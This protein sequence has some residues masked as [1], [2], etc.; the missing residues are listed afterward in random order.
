MAAKS[1]TSIP[2]TGK[3]KSGK[4]FKGTY[5]V[6]RFISKNG[7]TYALGTLSGKLGNRSVHR[8]N[9]AMPASVRGLT[10]GYMKDAVASC[11]VLHLVLGPLNLNLLGLKVTLGGGTAANQPIV[12]D[13]TAVPGAGNLL[14][15]LLCDVSNLLNSGGLPVQQVT[16][17][18][19]ILQ[20]LLNSPGLLG[21]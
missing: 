17:L 4:K 18:L 20:Q 6:D 19:N 1:L 16:G 13:I 7:K 9:V 8:S 11:P 5:S 12:L 15:N 14:G 2:I 10:G 3:T 21:L